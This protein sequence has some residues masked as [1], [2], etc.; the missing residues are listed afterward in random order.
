MAIKG[1]RRPSLY[2]AERKDVENGDGCDGVPKTPTSVS[3][4]GPL[5][6]RVL[7]AWRW[8]GKSEIGVYT[9]CHK[10]GYI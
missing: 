3:W 7:V 10:F 8:D 9:I 6:A 1:M 2:R 5:P 4:I